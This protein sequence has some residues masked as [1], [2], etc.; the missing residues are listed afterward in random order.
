M[1]LEDGQALTY[2]Q[3]YRY[4][5]ILLNEKEKEIAELKKENSDLYDS[6][7]RINY[8]SNKLIKKYG[9]PF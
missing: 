9:L 7:E 2:R 8:D 3:A 1:Y 6:L 5:S 4:L